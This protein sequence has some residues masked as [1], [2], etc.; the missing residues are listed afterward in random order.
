M[1]RKRTAEDEP[2]DAKVARTDP[3]DKLHGA[4]L[5]ALGLRPGDR[6][7]VSWNVGEE[8][9]ESDEHVW[10]PAV[11]SG[12]EGP[13]YVLQYEKLG[14]TPAEERRVT[15]LSPDMLFDLT[16]RKSTGWRKEGDESSSEEEDE[17]EEE[18]GLSIGCDVKFTSS[19]DGEGKWLAG[20]VLEI[21]GDKVDILYGG[22]DVPHHIEDVPRKLVQKVVLPKEVQRELR[23]S[24]SEVS[25]GNV[26][27]FFQA[28]VNTCTGSP[29]FRRLPA[30]Q[31]AAFAEKVNG[32]RPV[33]E[34]EL[35]KVQSERGHGCI[36]TGEDIK[37]IIPKVTSQ[38]RRMDSSG[39]GSG[40]RS[41][42]CAF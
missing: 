25:H 40:E 17:A 3:V 33:F 16:E 15:F 30:A 10:W 31:Q 24:D 14:E 11:V 8:G 21:K 35:D 42:G 1:D 38:L 2:T 28:F 34:E 32:M 27:E 26:D 5:D 41:P 13:A 7:E 37:A 18:D 29:I 36:I 39:S 4:S 19:E 6:I 22:E 12:G 20:K 9:E 23:R